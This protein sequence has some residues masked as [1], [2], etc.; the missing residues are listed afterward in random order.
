MVIARRDL[1]TLAQVS[2]IAQATLDVAMGDSTIDQSI[3]THLVGCINAADAALAT[4]NPSPTKVDALTRAISDARCRAIAE[5]MSWRRLL[6]HREL[7]DLAIGLS[8]VVQQARELR[9]S[10]PHHQRSCPE[11][12]GMCLLLA[13][14]ERSLE[15][16]S[17][18]IVDRRQTI[19]EWR[20]L[21][22]ELD[23]LI[24]VVAASISVSSDSDA[25]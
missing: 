19:T 18:A 14:A 1:R 9:R 17:T 8:N 12:T 7:D 6:A 21:I 16:Q 4:T 10:R 3:I 22:N 15:V 13:I 11:F 2:L 25:D 24:E 5:G 20:S 23:A